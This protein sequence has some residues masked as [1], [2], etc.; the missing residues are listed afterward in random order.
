MEYSGR[1]PYS[2]LWYIQLV[3]PQDTSHRWTSVPA[4]VPSAHTTAGHAGS[5]SK[6]QIL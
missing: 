3:D 2:I 6:S 4:S 1:G 5:T